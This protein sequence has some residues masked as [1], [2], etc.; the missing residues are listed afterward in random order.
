V[1][2]VNLLAGGSRRRPASR[3]GDGMPQWIVA[4]PPEPELGHQPAPRLRVTAWTKS[5]KVDPFNLLRGRAASS[6]LASSSLA[7]AAPTGVT[8]ES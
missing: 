3:L 7:A 5:V 2:P 6:F 4:G 1:L 8:S